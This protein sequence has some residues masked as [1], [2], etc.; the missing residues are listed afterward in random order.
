[1]S[2]FDPFAR[3]YDLEFAGFL[4]DLPLYAGYAERAA[5][6]LLELG[7]GTGRLLLPLAEV[8]HTLTGVDLSPAMLEQARRRLAAAGLAER[9]TLVQDDMRGLRRLGAA[10]FRLAFCAINSFLHLPDQAAQIAAL[11]AIRRH[12]EPGGWLIL[13]LFHPHPD[14]LGGY[15]G[16][17]VHETSFTA[18]DGAR[19][20]KFASRTLDAAAQTVQTVFFY[21]R[22]APDGRPER[23]VA[24]FAM[25]YIHRFE[26]GLLLEAAGFVLED[27]LGDYALNPFESDSLHL[28]AVARP[29]V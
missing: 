29:R 20:D 12:L 28:I 19:I 1:M 6:P 8:G 10:R 14:V 16:R 11:R 21:D 26:L 4:D 3:Y 27:L 9:V 13:D 15:D 5:G 25:R 23:T 24:P 22:L 17:L 18:D 2:I 7:C